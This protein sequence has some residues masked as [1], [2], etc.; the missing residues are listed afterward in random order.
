MLRR[1][2]RKCRQGGDLLTCRACFRKRGKKGR[3]LVE[4]ADGAAEEIGDITAT[5]LGPAI[6]A[7]WN[8]LF[9]W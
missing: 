4:A 8:R 2:T 5:W 7:V 1:H 6:A 3:G 9:G